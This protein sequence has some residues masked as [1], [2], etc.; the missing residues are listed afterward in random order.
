MYLRFI[1]EHSNQAKCHD[2]QGNA[3]CSENLFRNVYK[4]DI[5]P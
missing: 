2:I 5:N 1:V 3:V 4:I